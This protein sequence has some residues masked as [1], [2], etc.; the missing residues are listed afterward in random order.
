MKSDKLKIRINALQTT[1]NKLTDQ[2][3]ELKL[4]M[5]DEL[6][7]ELGIEKGTKVHIQSPG[8]S[9]H[10]TGIYQGYVITRIGNIIPAV[11]EIR[12][13]GEPGAFVIGV[14]PNNKIVPVRDAVAS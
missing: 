1:I 11:H 12:Y 4:Q 8:G 2:L 5:C 3:K 10:A 9:I 7:N 14:S 6:H 13:N